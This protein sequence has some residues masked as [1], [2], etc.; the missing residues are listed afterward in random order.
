[1]RFGRRFLPLRDERAE[2]AAEHFLVDH[3]ITFSAR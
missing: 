2:T 1:V 3:Q